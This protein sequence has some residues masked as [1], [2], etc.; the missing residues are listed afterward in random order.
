MDIV[1]RIGAYVIVGVLLLALNGV[2]I[3]RIY[4][5]FHRN[6]PSPVVAPF[7]IVGVKDDPDRGKVLAQMLIARVDRLN[8]ELTESMKVL[9]E[10][11]SQKAEAPLR[12]RPADIRFE[13]RVFDDASFGEYEPVDVNLSF[14]GV[15][16]G[17]LVAWGQRLLMS[18]RMISISVQYAGPKTTLSMT[19]NRSAGESLWLELESADDRAMITDLAY[20]LVKR[21]WE[22]NDEEMKKLTLEEFKALTMMIDDVAR[23]KL[24]GDR[25]TLADYTALYAQ[26][27]QLLTPHSRAWESQRIL[28]MCAVIADMAGNKSQA[29]ALYARLEPKTEAE[30]DWLEKT[31]AALNSLLT[32]SRTPQ[33]LVSMPPIPI[34]AIASSQKPTASPLTAPAPA[35]PQPVTT[36]ETAPVV[37]APVP[38]APEPTSPQTG[39]FASSTEPLL[40]QL[41]VPDGPME[42]EPVVA[43]I[44][45]DPDPRVGQFESLMQQGQSGSP[46]MTEYS[47]HLAEL[48]RLV[49]PKSRVVFVNADP[50][51]EAKMTEALDRLESTT[52]AKILLL[53]FGPLERSLEKR[54]AKMADRGVLVVIAAGNRGRGVPPHF[55]DDSDHVLIVS[56][57]DNQGQPAFFTQFSDDSVWAPGT[58]LLIKSLAGEISERS[59]TSYSAALAAGVAARVLGTDPMMSPKDVIKLLRRTSQPVVNGG[60]RLLNVEQAVRAA[61]GKE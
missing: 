58:G 20:V 26:I 41:H 51:T 24:A 48:L 37:P 56:A 29:S 22:S 25:A 6:E 40:A 10:S 18:D 1:L 27:D 2:F 46:Q 42:G 59:G 54:I 28:K 50:L 44:G 39:H 19:P 52:S 12:V 60:L 23:V 38:A 16:L 30:K 5:E 15:E 32:D 43:I 49:A 9:N 34:K 55:D 21:G 36:T 8:K 13:S 45:P 11:S 33:I 4:Y 57:A 17:G 53:T 3:R 7:R 14:G 47:T 61:R 35:A 31:K